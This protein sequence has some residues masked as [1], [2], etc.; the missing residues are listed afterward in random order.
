MLFPRAAY[1]KR[2]KQELR[3]SERARHATR[4]VL[5][6]ISGLPIV[7]ETNAFRVDAAVH[8]FVPWIVG[9]FFAFSCSPISPSD[10]RWASIALIR[11]RH[12]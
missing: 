10:I 11:L 8:L 6:A 2:F 7:S 9:T 3:T 5:G 12:R 1:F 4:R